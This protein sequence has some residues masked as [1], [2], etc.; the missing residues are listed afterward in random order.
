M[1]ADLHLHLYPPPLE[2]AVIERHTQGSLDSLEAPENIAL[3][4]GVDSRAL[5]RRNCFPQIAS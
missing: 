5:K 4:S 2:C 3:R 1:I